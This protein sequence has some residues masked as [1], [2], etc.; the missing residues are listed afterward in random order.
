VLDLLVAGLAVVLVSFAT[1]FQGGG[2]TSG[3]ALGVAMVNILGFGQNLAQFI[4][5]YTELE[6]SLGAVARV[7]EY[8][9]GLASEDDEP[10]QRMEPPADWPS[11]G[12]VRIKNITVGYE[13]VPIFI[14]C[15]G[16]GNML[17]VY[18]SDGPP[19]LD[20]FSLEVA[21]GQKVGIAGRTG[22]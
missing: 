13:Y 16:S 15:T 9:T 2:S 21:P 6:T 12:A 17:T 3:A 8:V 5:F 19:V 20:G 11:A 7:K 4:F 1:Q 22:R 10:D 14:A 18:N